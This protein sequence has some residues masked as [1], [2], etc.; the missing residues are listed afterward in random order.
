M[1]EAVNPGTETHKQAPLILIKVHK[2]S[3]KE[4]N[5]SNIGPGSKGHPEAK[6]EKE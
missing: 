2:N 3:V 1:H 5:F 4:N 6:K